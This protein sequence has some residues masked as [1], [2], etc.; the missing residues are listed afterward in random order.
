MHDLSIKILSDITIF[1]KYAKYIPELSRRETWAELCER[2]SEMHIKKYPD[3]AKEISDVY[4]DFVLTKK[5]LP[6]MRSMQFAGKP[7]ELSPNRIYNCCFIPIDDY[8]AF[9]E[10]MFLLLGGTGVGFS[11]QRH[12]V[13]KL[14]PVKKPI[15]TRRFVVG[16]SI[17]G[18]SDAIK[19]LVSAYF[20]GKPMP[21]FDFSDIRQKGAA[22]VTSGGKAPGPEPLK[23]CVHNLQKILDRKNDGEQLSSLEVHDMICYIADAVLAGGIR[24]AALISLFNLDDEEM[25][26]CKFG[27]WYEL[28]PQRARSNNSVV[29]MRHKVK[30]KDFIK[31]WEKIKASGSGEPGLY[32]SNNSEWGSNPCCE[33]SLRSNQFCNLVEVNFS[34]I[35]SQQ[36]LNARC[37]AAAFIATLQA[38][39]TDFHYLRDIWKRTTEKDALIGVS[40]TGIASGAYKLCNLNEA[41]E[42]VAQENERVAKLLGINKAARQTCVKPAGTTSLVLGTSSGI[43]SWFD[44]Y[45]IR[46]MKLGKN[47]AIYK[48]LLDKIPE[49]IEDDFF[50]PNL[51]SFV[52]V[53]IAAPKNAIIAPTETALELLERIKILSEDWV[54]PGHFKGDNSHNVSATIYIKEDEWETVGEWMWKNR[55][56][57]NGLSVLPFNG[58][59]YTQA[60]HESISEE[61]YKEL[62]KYL[63]E[64]NLSEVQEFKDNTSVSGE[65]A[66]AGGA[67]EVQY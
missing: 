13:A 16:D 9:S 59:T 36:D 15:K 49:L 32:L 1:N 57:Y 46:R 26:T 42:C 44:R 20:I 18:W 43:H 64:I 12:H 66:C 61:K 35:E 51:D 65:V 28:N 10:I 60:P 33:I 48:Y 52:K 50:K 24:R 27:N 45:Y 4:N 3:L 39:Y 29:I 40:G 8:R 63:K 67:C 53:P 58:G 11:V 47:E 17:E 6:S 55:E 34:D 22:L 31:L 54:K 37:K 14:P 56:C 25:L 38:G 41:A 2:N 62:L 5:V 7:I 19:A 30:K 21:V 23:D